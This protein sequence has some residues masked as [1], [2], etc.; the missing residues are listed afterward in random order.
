MFVPFC[1][2]TLSMFKRVSSYS[3]LLFFITIIP[4]ISYAQKN[5]FGV[6]IGISRYTGD[7][8]GSLALYN[9]RPAVNISL[10]RFL[11][12]FLS[13]K[14]TL[15]YGTLFADDARS[16]DASAKARNI[17]FKSPVI[18]VSAQVQYDFFTL[19]DKFSTRTWSPFFTGGVGVFYFSP[20]NES[21]EKKKYSRIQ[22][23]LL[24]GGGIRYMVSKKISLSWELT[25]QKTF[26]DYLDNVSAKDPIS[27]TQRGNPNDKDLYLFSFFSLGY[28]LYKLP[29]PYCQ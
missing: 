13:L 2:F 7:L 9:V 16:A 23:A 6:G 19:R 10:N 25:L 8:A 22:P 12:P 14:Y 1:I 20:N 24:I 27:G 17:R 26:T 28:T 15:S 4:F 21:T 11:N 3:V 5:E 18:E 29:C